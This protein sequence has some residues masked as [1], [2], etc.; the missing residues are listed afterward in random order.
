MLQSILGHNEIWDQSY[1]LYISFLWTINLIGS[2]LQDSWGSST[3]NHSDLS[4]LSLQRENIQFFFY[5]H[6]R[7]SMWLEPSTF[8]LKSNSSTTKMAFHVCNKMV[9]SYQ[10]FKDDICTNHPQIT[11][12]QNN[13]DTVIIG[14]IHQP[15]RHW[16]SK[17]IKIL[18]KILSSNV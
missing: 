9:K 10:K 7:A 11:W 3:W 18:N 1:M 6:I 16:S 12:T 4:H 5:I 17:K 13:W 2:T 8:A 14:V 15:N